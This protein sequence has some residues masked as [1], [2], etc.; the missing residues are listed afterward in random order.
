M[1][2]QKNVETEVEEVKVKEVKTAQHVPQHGRE[3][4]GK[5]KITIDELAAFLRAMGA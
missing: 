5:L 2:D 3:A 4:N 1:T